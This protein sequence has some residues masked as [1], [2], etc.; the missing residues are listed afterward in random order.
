[1]KKLILLL[2]GIA[3][4]VACTSTSEGTSEEENYNLDVNV[5]TSGKSVD[6]LLK[7]ATKALEKE[8]WDTA[9][10]YYNAAYQ[11]DNNDPRAIIYSTLANIAKISID[12]K[13]TTLIKE[14]F[15][16]TEYPN[17]LN[18]LFSDKWMKE[19]PSYLEWSYYDQASDRWIEWYYKGEYNWCNDDIVTKDGYYYCDWR[20]DKFV[21]VTSTQRRSTE[22][23]PAVNTPNW[24]KGSGT[25]FDSYLVNN[26]FSVDNWALSIIAN[27]I[28]RNSNGFNSTLD[29]VIDAV[30]GTSYNEAVNRLKKLEN[31]EEERITLDP[32]FIE[33]FGLEEIFDEYD[34]IGWAEVNVVL[35]A[36]LAVKASLE[37]VQTYD[38]N[39]DLNWLKFAWSADDDK[40]EQDFI[41]RFKGLSAN[42]VP[43]NNNFLKPRA[44]KSMATPKAT[45][46][47]AIK[48]LQASYASIKN[49]N[50]YPT[51]V[52]DAY[53]SIN[54]GF[55]KLIAAINNDGKFY[56]PKDDPT[57]IKTWPTTS[58]NTQATIDLG[59]I[60]TLGY[61]SLQNILE[62]NSDKPVFY[63]GREIE[64][65]EPHEYCYTDWDYD[66]NDEYYEYEVCD[67]Y[68]H[69]EYHYEYAP[70]TKSNYK[71]EIS[72]GGR[73]S[74][75]LNVNKITA[76]ADKIPTDEFE[77]VQ[78]GLGGEMA[79]AVFEKYYP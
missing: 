43:F 16:F 63:L 50:L 20:T 28:D 55:D 36:M 42:Q 17:K 67:V 40:L 57:K 70:L 9:V 54:D 77:Y 11:K 13:V 33:K 5:P 30:F 78:L 72:R 24:I 49:S 21:F 44:G 71:S 73:L 22:R 66:Y 60:F 2:I 18:A 26:T 52:K 48:G 68:Y 75:K 53:P 12:P 79:K 76:I 62:T 10:A 56:I 1:M 64:T 58:N 41:N 29:E 69:Y 74:L 7:D 34:K 15:G 27:V 37:W 31:R 23:L 3:F 46:V 51:E 25:L 6:Q 39:T 65:E 47:A 32:Y 35:S 61:F 45:Y 59:K 38:L 8:E 19:M 14:N 4:F